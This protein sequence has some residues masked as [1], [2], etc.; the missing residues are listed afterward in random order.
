MKLIDLHCDTANR[1]HRKN[2]IL[3]KNDFHISLDKVTKYDNYAQFTAFYI[4]SRLSDE[5]GYLKFYEM[6]GYFSAELAE[7]KERIAK[8]TDGRELTAV[9]ESDRAAAVFSVEDA[10]ILAGDISRLDTLYRKGVRSLVLLWGGE[11]IIG[12]SHNTDVGLTDFGRRVMLRCFE[13][14]IIPDVSHA[15][16][17]SADEMIEIA[18]TCSKPVI[19]SHSNSY[20]VYPHSRNLRDRHFSAIRE[21]GGLAGISLCRSH[22][23]P[24]KGANAD[25]VLRHIEHYLSLG[26]ED[27]V[28]LGC[29]F[30]G[31]DLP[32]GI[33]D[34]TY[35]DVIADRLAKAGYS[36]EIIEKI[37]W[38]NAKR[39]IEENIR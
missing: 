7:N 25:D 18:R 19:A 9:W 30:D 37:F 22:L 1:I 4:E 13:L 35:L 11:T 5:E 20:A 3:A 10:R 31:A 8:I 6:Y 12:G 34:I 15:S 16:E 36:D 39:F 38:K 14:G 21:L 28:A 24:G 26:G 23:A 2:A 33:R 17:R 29:D 32:D 27:T